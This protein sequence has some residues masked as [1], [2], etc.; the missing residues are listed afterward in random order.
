MRIKPALSTK[1]I[2]LLPLL[3]TAVFCMG[4]PS[5]AN[6]AAPGS[7]QDDNRA[8]R[9]VTAD[10][11][12]KYP[13]G[14]VEYIEYIGGGE[15][16]QQGRILQSGVG[17]WGIDINSRIKI[18]IDTAGMRR[19][20]G[21]SLADRLP[22]QRAT[23]L[24]QYLTALRNSYDN[25]DSVKSTVISVL[26]QL[27]TIQADSVEN[28][29]AQ[30]LHELY[31]TAYE[32]EMIPALKGILSS[33][34]SAIELRLSIQCV[35]EGDLERIV[36]EVY[37]PAARSPKLYGINWEG[38][39]E[40]YNGELAWLENE[41][42]KVEEL[43]IGL[44]ISAYLVKRNPEVTNGEK[45]TS[46]TLHLPGYNTVDK[47]LA[48]SFKK[49]YF[50]LTGE[51][52]ELFTNYENLRANV[53]SAKSAAE[54]LW[55][56]AKAEWLLIKAD[57]DALAGSISQIKTEIASLA[58]FAETWSDPGKFI[59]DLVKIKDELKAQI[60]EQCAGEFK[61]LAELVQGVKKD[62]DVL[63]VFADLK[64]TLQSKSPQEAMSAIRSAVT[65]VT[66]SEGDIFRGI[67]VL[68]S[69]AWSSRLLELKKIVEVLKGKL[70]EITKEVNLFDLLFKG[71]DVFKQAKSSFD[72]IMEAVGNIKA[73]VKKWLENLFAS[74]GPAT[75]AASFEVPA[76]QVRR[77]LAG[78]IDTE[79]DLE[80][81][82]STRDIGDSVRVF[83]A[84]FCGLEEKPFEKWDDE[85]V[86]KAFGIRGNPFPHLALVYRFNSSGDAAEDEAADAADDAALTDLGEYKPYAG[87]A[88]T[89]K[90]NSWPGENDSGLND[91][92]WRH[93]GLGFSFLSLDF[94][95]NQDIE[96]G[97]AGVVTLW[98]DRF[99]GGLG[100][101]L[102]VPENRYFW[103][104]SVRIESWLTKALRWGK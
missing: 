99:M 93:L 100:M 82:C 84:L 75:A 23:D 81:V 48:T 7:P 102:S 2:S 30:D 88:W 16:A 54:A 9:T 104:F 63:E 32:E 17:N 50:E 3:A 25:I 96:L 52:Q 19:L 45:V 40:V 10:D 71:V 26:E 53:G 79:F 85:F 22:N 36:G 21:G 64:E 39:V 69:G 4:L 14:A 34:V 61:K 72:K 6:P 62:L 60:K 83:Y 20:C 42:S 38:L 95:D 15:M 56:A 5:R 87:V 98:E 28:I 66:G 35:S 49:V 68:Y 51:Q 57:F 37:A 92:F 41:L 46:V 33:L 67:V 94:D 13:W 89:L 29:S 59:D 18:K 44:E 1:W 65:A 74:S 55:K 78:N 86:L 24:Q 11:G 97:I 70:N 58:K 43:G 101:N 27:K 73:E 76:G 31:R 47:C 80:T 8:N 103:F 91:S 90:Y 12:R 77:N